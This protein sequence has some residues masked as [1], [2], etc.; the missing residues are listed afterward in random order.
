M[1]YWH[2]SQYADWLAPRDIS[3]VPSDPLVFIVN[4][5]DALSDL[6]PRSVRTCRNQYSAMVFVHRFLVINP[7]T[8]LDGE[9]CC[10]LAALALHVAIEADGRSVP[11]TVWESAVAR[12]FQCEVVHRASLSA[13]ELAKPEFVASLSFDLHV[14]HPFDT[15]GLLVADL[16][17]PS[18]L[19]IAVGAVNSLYRT[20]A[21]VRVAPYVIAV[22]AVACA[23]LLEE[24]DEGVGVAD[25][26]RSLPV[27]VLAVQSVLIDVL[28][29]FVRLR[30]LPLPS[31]PKLEEIASPSARTGRSVSRQSSRTASS[32]PTSGKRKRIDSESLVGSLAWAL[33]PVDE[34]R[35]VKTNN[36]LPVQYHRPVSLS[37]LK[38]LR[39]LAR[40]KSVRGIVSLV[41]VELYPP[42]EECMHRKSMGVFSVHGFFDSHGTQFDSIVRLLPSKAKL[43]DVIEQLLSAA[44][45]LN[46]HKICHY[47]IE[48]ENIMVTDTSVKIASLS[49][50]TILPS[51]PTNL[52]SI[53]Y[54]P[55]EALI[56]SS[57]KDDPLALDLW[58]L[59]CLIAEIARIFSTRNRYEEPLFKLPDAMPD[60]PDAKCPIRDIPTYTNCRHLM[61]IACVLNGAVLPP[62]DVW[63]GITKRSNFGNVALLAEFRKKRFPARF[64]S[65]AGSETLQA[66]LRDDPNDTLLSEIV[67]AL[68][69]W[70]PERRIPP[71]TCLQRIA[72]FRLGSQGS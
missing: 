8:T 47:S 30:E 61:K 68:L 50:A 17:R 26:L 42:T 55:P 19:P 27:D 46:E 35:P 44:H 15:V 52:P 59:G 22:G 36:R 20:R 4:A 11:A 39:E 41:D 37:E 48:P 31:P 71:R 40:L 21:I 2:S 9:T 63:P 57:A 32:K 3:D 67:K 34:N 1:D 70:C 62:N 28:L 14:H 6:L 64:G 60:R 56:G 7:L 13:L 18:L 43:V 49:T 38:L 65:D 53:H 72:K 58:S 10:H 51:I 45:F 24:G 12:I 25:W 69:R 23:L 16:N 33:L 54:R 5:I 29:P 66:Y